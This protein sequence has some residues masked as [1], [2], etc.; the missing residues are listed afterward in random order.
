MVGYALFLAAFYVFVSMFS[1]EKASRS[2]GKVLI[3]AVVATFLIVSINDEIP[4]LAGVGVA[5]LAAVIVALAG[6]TFWMKVPRVQALKIAGSYIVF[7][8]A[9]SLVV[10]AL[11]RIL[12]A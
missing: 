6:L 1:G 2:M 8:L 10:Y 12:A 4:G 9:Y 11:I 7:V 3:V 5:C